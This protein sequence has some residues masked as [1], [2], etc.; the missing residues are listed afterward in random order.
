MGF[1]T[2]LDPTLSQITNMIL[3]VSESKSESES[4]EEKMDSSEES[5]ELLEL[6]EKVKTNEEKLAKHR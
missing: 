4:V 1:L 6:R 2:I 5:R 3:N